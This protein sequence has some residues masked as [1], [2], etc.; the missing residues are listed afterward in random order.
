MKKLFTILTVVALTTTMSFRTT[1][2]QAICANWNI[3]QMDVTYQEGNAD[4]DDCIQK[5]LALD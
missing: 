3:L 5:Q 2:R 1:Q 4:C